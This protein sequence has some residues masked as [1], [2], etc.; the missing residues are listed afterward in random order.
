MGHLLRGLSVRAS[1]RP[2]VH[3]LQQIDLTAGD[4]DVTASIIYTVVQKRHTTI[5]TTVFLTEL[6]NK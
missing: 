3:Y 5:S 6:L 2:S 1:V 4:R